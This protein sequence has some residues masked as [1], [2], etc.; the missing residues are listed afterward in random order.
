MAD[1]YG[2]QGIR[3]L[4]AGDVAA[5]VLDSLN[6]RIDPAKEAGNLADIK[7][8]VGALST[9]AAGSTNGLLTSILAAAGG[10]ALGIDLALYSPDSTAG[11]GGTSMYTSAAFANDAHLL[12]VVCAASVYATYLIQIDPLGGTAWATHWMAITSESSP[13]VTVDCGNYK[14]PSGG[15][16]HIVKTNWNKQVTSYD[17]HTTVNAQQ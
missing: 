8:R 2:K 17:L 5:G 15:K 16:V 4:D 14:V 12:S 3:T 11:N 6:A 10:G 1:T 13:T 9:P 7:D